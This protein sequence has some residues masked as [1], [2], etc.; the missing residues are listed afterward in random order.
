MAITFWSTLT[1]AAKG[2]PRFATGKV[3]CGAMSAFG[4]TRTSAKWGRCPQLVRADI[5]SKI[6]ALTHSGPDEAGNPAVQRSP[7]LILADPLYC[8]LCNS[9]N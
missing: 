4:T 1:P 7:D 9:I 3:L 5:S 2:Q 8:S 6:G